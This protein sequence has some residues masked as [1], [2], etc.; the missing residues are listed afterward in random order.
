M[1]SL[2]KI[3]GSIF[4]SCFGHWNTTRINNGY[5]TEYSDMK[6]E[7]RGKV[8][9]VIIYVHL[10]L[11][12]ILSSQERAS[13]VFVL[14]RHNTILVLTFCQFLKYKIYFSNTVMPT[15]HLT[16]TSVKIQCKNTYCR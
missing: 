16:Y 13:T 6:K 2:V 1:A 10:Q 7:G 11:R 3:T 15:F 8:V 14:L 9:E 12:R 5:L 4:G